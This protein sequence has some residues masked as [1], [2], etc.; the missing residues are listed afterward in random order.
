[1]KTAKKLSKALIVIIIVGIGFLNNITKPASAFYSINPFYTEEYCL[2]E[3]K[4][5]NKTNEIK[6]FDFAK[7]VILAGF[8][9]LFPS[10]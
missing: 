4:D 9:H 2:S 5:S 10:L 8:I 1:M 7:K 6:L 3:K